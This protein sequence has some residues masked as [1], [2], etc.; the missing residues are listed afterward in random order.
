MKQMYKVFLNDRVIKIGSP[1]NI[2]IN[3]S[4]VRFSDACSVEEIRKWFNAFETGSLDEVAVVHDNPE[5][6]F[7]LFQSAF[8]VV[9][10]AGGVVVA[11]DSLLFIFRNGKWDLPKGKLDRNESAEE[12]ALR[13]VE[14]ETGIAAGGIDFK[15]PST[16]HIYK[17]P[18]ADTNNQWI[19]KETAWFQMSCSDIIPGTPQKEEGITRVKWIAVGKLEEVMQ[20]TYKNLMQLIVLYHK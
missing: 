2:T 12:A 13:E 7:R 10:A 4:T 1:E 11:G 15:L 8:K 3:Q 9:Q 6:F 19:F 5:E 18:Y 20:N 17:S 16:F 14:E